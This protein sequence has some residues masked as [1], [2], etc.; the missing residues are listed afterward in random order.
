[1]GKRKN[2]NPTP[3]VSGEFPIGIFVEPAPDR[4]SDDTYAEIRAMNANFVVAQ[5]LTTPATTDWALEKALTNNLKILVTDTG[6]R[7]IQSEWLSQNAD[8]GEGVYLHN[9]GSIGQTFTTPDVD[10]LSLAVI[11]F[12][13]NGEWPAGA[14]VTLNVYDSPDKGTRIAAMTL[15]GPIASRYPEFR[16]NAMP[17]AP[18]TPHYSVAANATYYLE[19]TTDS[20]TALGPFCT[21]AMDRYEGGQAYVN[22]APMPD[23]LYFQITLKT[24]RGG[25][26][27]AFS[28]TGRP[29][30]AYI[31][32]LVAHYK[33]HP[34]VL[35]YN[36]IDEPFAE[37]YPMMKETSDKI[38]ELDPDRLIY[39]NHYPLN[40]EGKGYFSLEGTPPMGYEDY[41]SHW[42]DTNPDMI[43]FDYYPFKKE[44]FDEHF[45]YLSLEYYRER[46]LAHHIDFWAYIQSIA[47]D[48]FFILEPTEAQMRFQIFSTLAYGAKG[49]V[50]WTY[51]NPTGD[52]PE[53]KLMHDA[54][55]LEDGSKN[56]TYDY[57]KAINGEILKIGSV[58]LSLTSVEVYHTGHIPPFTKRLP[59]D[60]F[61]Q[62]SEKDSSASMIIS[63]F[64]NEAGKKYVMVINR[65]FEHSQQLTFQLSG[66]LQAVKEVCKQ[67]GG[68]IAT[69][70]DATAGTLSVSFAPGDGKLYAL[71]D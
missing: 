6:I 46:S 13:Q 34:A 9:D 18:E 71:G 10:D 59:S 23:D 32:T 4:T 11:S 55:I 7:W 15:N 1:M 70:Y 42:L 53:I 43:S 28:P 35:G 50:Y 56:K 8:D 64:E 61:W 40:D 20:E 54:L 49:Y 63:L 30:D 19:L 33:S 22:G 48:Y 37:L 58:L 3:A 41:V 26:I 16:L 47:Y 21:S 14:S 57:A 68:E 17:V 62:L 39:V 45:Y 27:S 52:E 65:D 60:F 24:S 44:G 36:L 5:Q 25:T 69:T 38:K 2:N 31:E 12:K 29:S 51:C 67:T 66:H